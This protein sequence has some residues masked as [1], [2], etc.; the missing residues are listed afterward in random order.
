MEIG[1]CKL[2]P[3]LFIMPRKLAAIAPDLSSGLQPASEGFTPSET[4]TIQHS[5]P[6]QVLPAY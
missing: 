6:M 4:L 5:I 2:I 3:L 1:I